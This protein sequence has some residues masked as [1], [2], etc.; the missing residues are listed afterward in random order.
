M[1][2]AQGYKNPEEINIK[3]SRVY[4]RIQEWFNTRKPNH[5][6]Q[7]NNKKNLLTIS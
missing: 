4:I 7:C 3:L 1:K 2:L 6:N 5:V